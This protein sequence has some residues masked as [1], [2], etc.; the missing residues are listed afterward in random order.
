MALPHAA[1]A[2]RPRLVDEVGVLVVPERVHRQLGRH[3]RH[4]AVLLLLEEVPAHDGVEPRR[5]AG[6]DAGGAGGRDGQ[7]VAV[8]QAVL[9]HVARELFPA[10]FHQAAVA[11]ILARL[12]AAA[13]E[14]RVGTLLP[15]D[16]A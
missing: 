4:E 3:A 12:P 1:G 11:E 13:L 14:E 8:A 6:D 9:G 15:R 10:A 5:R 2:H 7:Q 16:G